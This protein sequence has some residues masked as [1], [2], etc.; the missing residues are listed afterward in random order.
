MSKIKNIHCFGTS[1]TAGGGFEWGSIEKNELLE[2]YYGHLDIPKNQWAFS[3]P[4]RFQNILNKN[5]D[6][7]K[8][9]NHGKQ[10][11]GNQRIYRKVYEILEDKNFDKESSLFIIELSWT[12]RREFYYYPLEDYIICN[13]GFKDD[14]SNPNRLGKISGVSLANTYWYQNQKTDKILENDTQLFFDFMKKTTENNTVCKEIIRNLT[15]FFAFL[16][17]NGIKYYISSFPPINLAINQLIKVDLD[18][19]IRFKHNGIES[20]YLEIFIK[21]AKLTIYDETGGK[22][23]DSHAGVFGNTLIANQI[24]NKIV[25]QGDLSGQIIDTSK[26][27]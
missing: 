6:D 8:V 5:G 23:K 17:E 19:I 20:D 9:H 14:E 7:I 21:N 10:G 4:G 26:I 15:M 12:G 22:Y 25:K 24:Y 13:Y 18:R 11:Y 3:W 16:N 2:K 1:Y 27:L